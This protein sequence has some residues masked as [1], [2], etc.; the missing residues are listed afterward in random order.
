MS[1][2]SKWGRI[3]FVAVSFA[4]S[5][6]LLACAQG[7]PGTLHGGLQN[8]GDDGGT[9]AKD[10][11]GAPPP[12]KIAKD[13]GAHA[14]QTPPAPEPPT[15]EQGPDAGATAPSVNMLS[16]SSASAN[17]ADTTLTVLGSNFITGAKVKFGALDLATTFNG[18]GSLTAKIP[19]ASLMT[20]GGVP[21]TVQNPAPFAGT[22]V[23]TSF[24]V[25]NAHVTITTISPAT[26]SVGSGSVA[27]TVNGTGFGTVDKITFNGASLA[28]TFVNATQVT[29]SIPAS[30]LTLA[31]D[32]PVVLSSGGGVSAPASFRVAD[33]K[34]S[35]DTFSPGSVPAGSPSTYATLSGRGFDAS[36]KVSVNGY[37]ATTV[38][39]SATQV[40]ALI[41]DYD[42]ATAGTVVLRIY[43]TSGTGT[44]SY[45]D[46]LGNLTVTSTTG[47]TPRFI[48]YSPSSIRSGSAATFVTLNGASFDSTTGVSVNGLVGNVFHDSATQVSLLLSRTDLASPTTLTIRVYNDAGNG[49][50]YYA[51]TVG[52][53]D[54]F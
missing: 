29:A 51:D 31:G 28:T 50:A 13:A 47:T 7:S 17:A 5:L 44:V 10:K 2:N 23:P 40:R 1:A 20:P 49:T 45:A 34:P 15:P 24:T 12:S 32:F 52:T 41:K 8:Q 18:P 39:D 53:I 48:S 22:S 46:N 36:S 54:V 16:P 33:S 19:S 42:L 3:A 9:P 27:L 21:I 11:T 25:S 38:F 6:S 37:I 4:S 14:A 30:A 35:F 43:N 26:A